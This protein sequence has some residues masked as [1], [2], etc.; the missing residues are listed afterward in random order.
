MAM[1]SSSLTAM[2][3]LIIW[4]LKTAGTKPCADA[5]NRG[6]ARPPP[7]K[8]AAR[9]GS[10]ATICSPGR[11]VFSSRFNSAMDRTARPDAEHHR[12]DLA[13]GRVEN[14]PRGRLA[15][16]LRN[17]AGLTNCCGMK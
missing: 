12:V 7:L 10:T 11:L 9:L 1:A 4:R 3:R 15:M 6:G 8:T 17:F 16:D 14:L 2:T 5:R 13:I